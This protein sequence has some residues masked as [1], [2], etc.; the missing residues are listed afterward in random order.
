MT[1]KKEH[2]GPREGAGRPEK[3]DRK[4]TYSTKLRPDQIAFLRS[5]DNAGAWLELRIDGGIALRLQE[6]AVDQVKA[7]AIPA[8][9]LPLA[10]RSRRMGWT[11][12]C[13]VKNHAEAKGATVA[14]KAC[15][16]RVSTGNTGLLMVE[17]LKNKIT[18]MAVD[19]VV[20]LQAGFGAGVWVADLLET[21]EGETCP[22]AS[23]M[24]R[25]KK[26]ITPLESIC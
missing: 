1:K 25:D 22:W 14:C 23:D 19:G 17:E 5:L 18:S 24:P 20:Y 10:A 21:K 9:W 4:T 26:L 6:L 2:G 8:T 7:T 16:T 12:A 13:G 3:S 15:R 11:C